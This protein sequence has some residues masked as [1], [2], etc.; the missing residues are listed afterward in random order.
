M[1]RVDDSEF[2]GEQKIG[3]GFQPSPVFLY[4]RVAQLRV[5]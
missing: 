5:V 4:S 2:A 3:G 1:G